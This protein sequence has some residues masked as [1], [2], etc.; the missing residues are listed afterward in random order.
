VR[1]VVE[2]FHWE[3]MRSE[4][5]GVMVSG[6]QSHQWECRTSR[7]HQRERDMTCGHRHLR[8]RTAPTLHRGADYV[9][10]TLPHTRDSQNNGGET[11]AFLSYPV[12]VGGHPCV[13]VPLLYICGVTSW[14]FITNNRKV[15]GAKPKFPF[16]PEH[17]HGLSCLIEFDVF[18]ILSD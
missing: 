4:R 17:M 2:E 1:R 9:G 15:T 18:K 14:V 5:K 16:V 7:S 8:S 10:T 11:R 3:G 6:G 12:D 13:C